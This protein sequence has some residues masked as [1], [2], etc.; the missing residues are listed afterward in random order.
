MIAFR[1][2]FERIATYTEELGDIV[3][4]KLPDQLFT[5]SKSLFDVISKRS[6]ISEKR[7]MLDNAADR[8]GF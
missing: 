1:D 5:G 8:D 3:G 4:R 6:Q 2:L 7:M